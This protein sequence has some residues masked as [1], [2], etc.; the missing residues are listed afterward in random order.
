MPLCGR[1]LGFSLF[2]AEVLCPLEHVQE[3]SERL[4]CG[5]SQAQLRLEVRG[6]GRKVCLGNWP[7]MRARCSGSS[8]VGQ[9][10]TFVRKHVSVEVGPG[11][12][13]VESGPRGGLVEKRGALLV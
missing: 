7:G 12:W 5:L 4:A 2:C 6:P 13:D 1:F 11:L 8:R 10:L 3:T 9:R